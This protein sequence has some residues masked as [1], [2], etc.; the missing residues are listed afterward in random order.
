MRNF[1]NYRHYRSEIG[2]VSWL[3]PNTRVCANLSATWVQK[4]SLSHH[5]IL[6]PQAPF[7]LLANATRVLILG[8]I[9]WLVHGAVSS[10]SRM[11]KSDVW[12][13]VPFC[14]DF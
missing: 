6:R 9:A 14:P 8:R 10:F 4:F 1:G 11:K 13:N 7:R 5:H 2:Q 3:K 12:R